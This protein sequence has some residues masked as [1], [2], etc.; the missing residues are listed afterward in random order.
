MDDGTHRYQKE[1]ESGER[2]VIGVNKFRLDEEIPIDIFQID[3]QDEVRQIERLSKVR[4]GRDHGLFTE[5]LE[6][7]Q[8][9]AR[10]KVRDSKVNI[11]PSMLEAVRA[12]ATIGEI[13][14]VLRRVFG[15][16]KP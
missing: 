5:S 6:R 15:E 10:K 2:V 3:P 16:Y 14:G 4:Q 11:V 8:D 9:V 7:L 1:V 13:Y 12:Y